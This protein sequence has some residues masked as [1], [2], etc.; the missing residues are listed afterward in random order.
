MSNNFARADARRARRNCSSWPLAARL[1]G[2]LSRPEFLPGLELALHSTQLTGLSNSDPVA[3]WTDASGY[4]RHGTQESVGSQ[5]TYQTNQTPNGRPAVQF[6][7]DDFLTIGSGTDIRPTTGLSIYAVHR[8]D[9]SVTHA[10]PV[11]L[12]DA[13]LG[14]LTGGYRV[15]LQV[16]GPYSRLAITNGSDLAVAFGTTTLDEWH[17]R[18]STWSMAAGEVLVGVDGQIVGRDSQADP[19]DYTTALGLNLGATSNGA[20]KFYQGEV[21]AVLIYSVGHSAVQRHAIERALAQE[22]GINR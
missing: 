9:S 6:D 16:S 2:R 5:P 11:L 8:I 17:I 19:I 12:E 21:A 10:F 22:Y 4:D 18:S 13:N 15:D 20:G 1:P 7:G 14:G 3:T